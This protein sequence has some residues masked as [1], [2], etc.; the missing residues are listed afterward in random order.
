LLGQTG[1]GLG[2]NALEVGHRQRIEFDTNRQAAL[3]L[4]NQVRRFG[5]VESAAGDEQDVIGTNHPVLGRYRRAFNQRQQVALHA[6]ARDVDAVGV[7]ARG[8]LVDFVKKDDAVLLDI[9]DRISLTSSS[10][11]S[12]AASSSISNRRASK[13][14]SLRDFLRPP[15]MF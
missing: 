4:G 8:D 3:Q 10:L 15:P 13:I 2:Q 5:Q 14:F 9:P 12:F 1:I 7:A 11:T 6:L